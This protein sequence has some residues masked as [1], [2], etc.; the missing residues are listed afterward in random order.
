MLAHPNA[1]SLT[2]VRDCGLL[3]AC[4]SITVSLLRFTHKL[5][6][7]CAC[8]QQCAS[9][10]R[11]CP[12]YFS[13]HL[14]PSPARSALFDLLAFQRQNFIAKLR[15]SYLVRTKPMPLSRSCGWLGDGHVPGC[16]SPT[17]LTFTTIPYH[18]ER[19]NA[20]LILLLGHASIISF[21]SC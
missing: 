2:D 16:R 4:S 20:A 17:P 1:F 11:A 10:T 14:T 3:F 19:G 21:T 9:F 8:L 12:L 6:K 13:C 7:L 18:L 5:A 15:V